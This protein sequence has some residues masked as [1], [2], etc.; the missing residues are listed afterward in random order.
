M[1]DALKA[2]RSSRGLRVIQA[3]SHAPRIPGKTPAVS[4]V[5]EILASF[6]DFL[7]PTTNQQGLEIIVYTVVQYSKTHGSGYFPGRITGSAEHTSA[8]RQ[9]RFCALATECNMYSKEHFFFLHQGVFRQLDK[10][11]LKC[12]LTALIVVL[13]PV[14]VIYLL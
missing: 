14:P 4:H 13:P 5:R 12:S 11:H 9:T 2:R 10:F 1:F 3:A 8:S 6:L 7:V